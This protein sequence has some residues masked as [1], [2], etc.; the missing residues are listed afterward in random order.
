MNPRGFTRESPLQRGVGAEVVGQR[1]GNSRRE[2]LLA[3]LNDAHIVKVESS[4][5]DS[6]QT[7]ED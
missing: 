1:P 7:F 4:A 5:N 3:N 6:A 2:R